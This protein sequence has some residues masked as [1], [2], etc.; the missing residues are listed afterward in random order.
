MDFFT[1][2]MTLF[3]MNFQ[4]ILKTANKTASKIVKI[5]HYFCSKHCWETC[6][7]SDSMRLKYSSIATYKNSREQAVGI[8]IFC[9]ELA[10][11]MYKLKK[12]LLSKKTKY[13]KVLPIQ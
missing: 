9:Q 13:V 11:E 3:N 5:K 4:N 2:S 10:E 12:I 1:G 6:E 8:S 7:I